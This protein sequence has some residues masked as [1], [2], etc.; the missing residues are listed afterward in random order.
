LTRPRFQQGLSFLLN[1]AITEILSATGFGLYPTVALIFVVPTAP[2]LTGSD[3]SAMNRA[4][5]LRPISL[6]RVGALERERERR[7]PIYEVGG[8]DRVREDL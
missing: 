6:I 1:A 4:G 3:E 2:N 5:G 8:F 7:T